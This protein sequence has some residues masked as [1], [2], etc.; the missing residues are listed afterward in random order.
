MGSEEIAER[1]EVDVQVVA[2]DLKKSRLCRLAQNGRHARFAAWLSAAVAA[3]LG[4]GEGRCRSG[5][6]RA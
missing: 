2:G 4:R 3:R 5:G 1:A 6:R